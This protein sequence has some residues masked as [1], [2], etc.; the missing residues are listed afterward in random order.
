MGKKSIKNNSD[1]KVEQLYIEA[2]QS[3]KDGNLLLLSTTE[4]KTSK[5][6]TIASRCRSSCSING[7]EAL[8]N[9]IQKQ[10]ERLKQRDTFS[11]KVVRI[12]PFNSETEGKSRAISRYSS[13]GSLPCNDMEC[14]E[15]LSS[16]S[17][18]SALQ[19]RPNTPSIGLRDDILNDSLL[20]LP[21]RNHVDEQELQA[22]ST[23][24]TAKARIPLYRTSQYWTEKMRFESRCPSIPAKSESEL[25]L[26]GFVP[27][28]IAR[29]ELHARTKGKQCKDTISLAAKRVKLEQ[30]T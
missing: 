4:Q 7:K 11:T 6:T 14:K 8:Q 26:H 21:L 19:S 3:A 9:A 1:K 10:Q 22:Q 17:S 13:D 18:G 12:F 2:L 24:F 23:T 15:T 20:V 5:T 25:R 16:T 27:L 29:E 28:L 30:K